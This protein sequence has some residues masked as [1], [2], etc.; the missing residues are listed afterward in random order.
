MRLNPSFPAA[1]VHQVWDAST[2]RAL[3]YFE[4][5]SRFIESVVPLV[6]DGAAFGREAALIIGCA[7]HA[8]MWDPEVSTTANVYHEQPQEPA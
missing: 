5:G 4:V 1:T 8:T 7:M 6:C 2:G 3:R